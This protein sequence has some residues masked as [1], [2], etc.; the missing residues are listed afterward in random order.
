VD[1]PGN[2]TIAELVCRA[3]DAPEAGA[4]E[5]HVADCPTC[6][7]MMAALAG[8]SIGRFAAATPSRA[9]TVP[10]HGGVVADPVPL[11][12]GQS[13]GRYRVLELLGAGGMGIVYAAHDPQLERAVAVKLLLPE[14]AEDPEAARALLLSEAQAMAKLRH[15]NLVAVHDVGVDGERVYIAMELIRGQTLRGWLSKPRA[16]ADVLRVMIAA[17]RGL[18]AAHDAGLVHRDFKPENVLC[19]AGGQVCVSDFGLALPAGAETRDVAGTPG[20]MA[21][22]QRAGAAPDPRADIYSFCTVLE[23]SVARAPRWLAQVCAR[24]RAKDPAARFPTMHTL[25]AELTRDRGRTRRRVGLAVGAAAVMAAGAIALASSA[26]AGAA[27]PPPCRGSAAELAAVWNPQRRAAVERAILATGVPFA[28]DTWTRVAAALDER[29]TRWT[30]MHVEACEAT[31]VHHTQSPALLDRR[32]TCLA[33]RRAEL[34]AAVT[35]LTEIDHGSVAGAVRVATG[36]PSLAACADPAALTAMAPPPADADPAALAQVRADVARAAVLDRAGKLDAA[37]ALAATAAAAAERLGDGPL[38]AEAHFTLATAHDSAGDGAAARDTFQRAIRAAARSGHAAIEARSLASLALLTLFSSDN[39]VA[40][41]HAD[42]ALAI[43]LRI[44]DPLLEASVRRAYARALFGVDFQAGMEQL[45]VGERRLDEAARQLPPA[46]VAEARLAYLEVHGDLE[47]DNLASIA[48][49]QAALDLAAA[50]YGPDHPRLASILS[51]M[52]D[53]AIQL[54]DLERA[55]GFAKRAAHVLAPYPGHD[56]VLRTLEA[57][58]DL[59]L[60]R[61]L[62]VLEEV[63]RDVER[64]AGPRSSPYAFALFDVAEALDLIGRPAD[65]L[66][67]HQRVVAIWENTYRGNYEML[68]I[69]YMSMAMLNGELGNLEQAELDILRGLDMA[70]RNHM[71][72]FVITLGEMTVAQIRFQRGRYAEACAH[73]AQHSPDMR[74][75]LDRSD[76]NLAAIDFFEAA[77]DWELQPTAPARAAAVRRARAA[78]RTYMTMI[79]PDRASRQMMEQWLAKMGAASSTRQRGAGGG[80]EGRGLE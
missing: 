49:Y 1:C 37:L 53:E 32:M 23:E 33:A 40:R 38:E 39:L 15:P 13:I 47:F 59:D 58:M 77:C 64:R 20:Y 73:A 76:P 45:A 4:V 21:P 19:G 12:A 14:L 63:A 22:E 66:A 8:S 61:R 9:A 11:R 28:A 55:R 48:H 26:G 65:S 44:R 57:E 27:G 54:D 17:G 74:A 5:A 34:D 16:A 29:S 36:M 7:R 78:Y 35:A 79:E 41:E 72:G 62:A 67:M 68:A 3:L 31:A 52:A 43:A 10:G 30:A 56:A 50:T 75:L 70:R 46:E 42:H 18:A 69:A 25:L 51:S 2:N 71:R 80:V 6:R 24:G 60:D